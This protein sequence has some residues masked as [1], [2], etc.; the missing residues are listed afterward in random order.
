MN[1]FIIYCNQ[2]NS[3]AWRI[4]NQTPKWVI[5][6][7]FAGM[8]VSLIAIIT[9]ISFLNDATCLLDT[10][11]LNTTEFI[12][13]ILT[14][15]QLGL[16][17]IGMFAFSSFVVLVPY[18]VALVETMVDV[19]LKECFKN[20]NHSKGTNHSITP[21]IP[22]NAEHPDSSLSVDQRINNIKPLIVACFWG[23]SM[24]GYEEDFTIKFCN[25]LKKILTEDNKVMK[26]G[27]IACILYDNNWTAEKW[28]SF[29]S[30]IIAFF[31]ALGMKQPGD[32]SHNKY[33]YSD[34][35]ISPYSSC[36]GEIDKEFSYLLDQKY[37]KQLKEQHRPTHN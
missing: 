34:G 15:K 14:K 37:Q 16:F 11:N 18:L 10:E 4:I 23:R 29:K 35:G 32:T 1:K 3:S 25:S 20:D 7:G 9:T 6:S 5:Y 30:W 36:F 27:R 26:L 24:W 8:T 2:V 22:Q 21:L 31:N 19:L 13:S 33:A 17:S 28:M 12:L